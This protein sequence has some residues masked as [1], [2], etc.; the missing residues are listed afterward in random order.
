MVPCSPTPLPERSVLE[1]LECGEEKTD[2]LIMDTKNKRKLNSARLC[3]SY[4]R[5]RYAL[6]E[7]LEPVCSRT[8][9]RL[10]RSVGCGMWDMGGV[11]FDACLGLS[12]VDYASLRDGAGGERR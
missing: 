3:P 11:L 9:R 4:T 5:R 12:T 6:S 8:S 7:I 1:N 2:P 10:G